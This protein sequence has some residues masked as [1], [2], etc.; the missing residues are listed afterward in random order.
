[1]LD[2]RKLNMLAELERLGT[3]AAVAKSLHLTAPGISMQIGALER[4]LGVRLTEKQGRRIV[5]TPA[6]QAKVDHTHTA[7]TGDHTASAAFGA[8]PR[9]GPSVQHTATI[10]AIGSP[11][12]RESASSTPQAAR[13]PTR[14]EVLSQDDKIGRI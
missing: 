6:G 12:G 8:R 9:P 10:S 2:I 4:E 14:P 5:V 13:L 7:A 1:M 11:S 3:I